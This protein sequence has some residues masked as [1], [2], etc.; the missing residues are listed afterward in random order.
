MLYD[1]H[2]FPAAAERSVVESDPDLV[3]FAYARLAFCCR[4][5]ESGAELPTPCFRS[6]GAKV[7]GSR[8]EQRRDDRRLALAH[9]ELVAERLLTAVGTEEAAEEDDLPRALEGAPGSS[10]WQ[11]T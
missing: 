5:H 3:V 6:L 10:R 11:I 4:V 2:W 7:A 9:N 8:S 1:Q